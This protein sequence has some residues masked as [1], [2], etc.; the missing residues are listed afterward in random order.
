M[1]VNDLQRQS[2]TDW[3]ALEAMLDEEIDYSDIPPLADSFFE[4]AQPRVL[5]QKAKVTMEV[6]QDI[7]N[8]FKNETED[9]QGCMQTAL[10]IYVEAH[11]E[12]PPAR[13]LS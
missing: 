2:R 13:A 4:H 11:K 1:S 12:Y 7:L 3:A 9:W 10:R 5:K 6:D 8:W